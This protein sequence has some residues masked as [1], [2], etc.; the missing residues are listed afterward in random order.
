MI[1]VK[2]GDVELFWVA[3]GSVVEGLRSLHLFYCDAGYGADARTLVAADAV[4][5]EKVEAVVA[6]F[7]EGG[8]F[9]GVREGYASMR[10]GLAPLRDSRGAPAKRLHQVSKGKPYPRPEAVHQPKKQ[11][12]C[13]LRVVVGAGQS[14]APS[15][16]LSAQRIHSGLRRP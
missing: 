4:F 2:A 13:D 9:V 1:N 3:A 16:P 11:K 6:I 14:P 12:S 7:G 5:G 15:F 8:F 10:G